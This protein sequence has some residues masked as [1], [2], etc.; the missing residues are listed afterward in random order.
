MLRRRCWAL[1]VVDGVSMSMPPDA[2]GAHAPPPRHD[3]GKDLTMDTTMHR[4]EP[5]TGV[6]F[7]VLLVPGGL[8]TSRG[9]KD[10][11][12]ASQFASLFAT[13]A[14]RTRVGSALLLLSAALL[15]WF[16]A[17]LNLGPQLLTIAR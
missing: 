3:V 10:E 6:L 9:A 1:V 2:T 5:F 15:L 16:V 12:S 14:T 8:M 7:E 11:L 4:W 13:S 17:Y